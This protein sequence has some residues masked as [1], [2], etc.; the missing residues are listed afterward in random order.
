MKKIALIISCEHAVNTIPSP[1]QSL[2]EPFKNLLESHEGI[3]SGALEIALHFKEVFSCDLIQS[4]T[5]RLLIDYNRSLNNR[6][7]SE[8]T[9]KLPKQKKQEIITQYYLPYRQRVIDHIEKHLATGAQV[10]HCSIHS[11]SPV[12]K[13]VIRN[14]EIGFLYDPQRPL[15]KKI[16]KEW[17]LEVKKQTG[18]YRIKMNYPYKGNSD[19]FTTT[20]RKKYLAE[21]YIGIE[22]ELNQ[23]L[24][25]NQNSLIHLKNCLSISFSKLNLLKN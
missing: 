16:A 3:D 11:F 10:I 7:F 25:R 24:T 14:A 5:S 6:C 2:F 15:E 22:I 18:E 21:E 17:R 8:I 1:Y 19:G 20:L 9:K 12:L 13:K 23:A 4:H